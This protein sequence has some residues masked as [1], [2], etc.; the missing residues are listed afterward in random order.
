M[1]NIKG[2]FEEYLSTIEEDLTTSAAT[3][4]EAHIMITELA[5]LIEQAQTNITALTP[6][7]EAVIA[8][9]QDIPVITAVYEDL[10]N[11][12]SVAD[13]KEEIACSW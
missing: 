10:V 5:G 13:V 3:I 9:E 8:V 11:I 4:D 1:K 2:S 7:V 6:V 12:G